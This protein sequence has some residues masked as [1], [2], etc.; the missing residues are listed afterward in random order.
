[1]GV[2]KK[3]LTRQAEER[4]KKIVK[5]HNEQYFH[6]DFDYIGISYTPLITMKDERGNKIT[7]KYYEYEKELIINT[8]CNDFNFTRE[9]ELLQ[10]I[11]NNLK[12]ETTW[13]EKNNEYN[14]KIN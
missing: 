9:K 6:V 11:E 7:I 1:M 3:K 4:I 2:A 12:D 13:E 14:R 10:I 8:R 5:E